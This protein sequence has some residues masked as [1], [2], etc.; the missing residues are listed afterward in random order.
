MDNYTFTV[1]VTCETAEEAEQVMAERLDPDED[2][3]FPYIVQYAANV[4]AVERKRSRKHHKAEPEDPM[5][6]GFSACVHCG[7][8]VQRVPGG[9]G[10]TW[11]HSLTGTVAG[12]GA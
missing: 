10:P 7:L 1:I 4:T 3:G 5:T 12:S 8:E 6:A 2:Y 9:N 11:V